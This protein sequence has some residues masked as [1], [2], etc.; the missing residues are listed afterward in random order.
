[1]GIRIQTNLT[2]CA[3]TYS[4]CEIA[5]NSDEEKHKLYAL[6]AVRSF[7]SKNACTDCPHNT[8]NHNRVPYAL[9]YVRKD[10]GILTLTEDHFEAD[11]YKH[12]GAVLTNKSFYEEENKEAIRH[13]TSNVLKK[14]V[15]FQGNRLQNWVYL[16]HTQEFLDRKF[17]GY[18]IVSV[19][20]GDP[21]NH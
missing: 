18:K 17:S 8:T 2:F 7:S 5:G 6:S 1:M 16:M 10:N 19:Y 9:S 15:L 14:A 4:D 13:A 20:L 3:P 21:M 12:S 11:L